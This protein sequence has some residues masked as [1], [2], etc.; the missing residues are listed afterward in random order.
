MKFNEWLLEENRNKT[1]FLTRN[2]SFVNDLIKKYEKSGVIV[3]N[4][5]VVSLDHIAK[6]IIIAASIYD[7]YSKDIISNN[8]TIWVLKELIDND[9]LQLTY[10]R[11]PED[12]YEKMFTFDTVKEIYQKICL[13]RANKYSANAEDEKND[14]QLA[15]LRKIIDVYEDKLKANN[16]IDGVGLIKD[17]LNVADKRE[18]SELLPDYI[19][20]EFVYLDEEFITLTN[21]EQNLINTL[22]NTF[23]G[24]KINFEEKD[25]LNKEYTFF[26]GYGLANEINYVVNDILENKYNFGDVTVLYTSSSMEPYIEGA[27]CG[28]NI[29]VSFIKGKSASENIVVQLIRNIIA[30]ANDDFSEEKLANILD[31]SLLRIKNNDGEKNEY[32]ASYKYS[33]DRYIKGPAKRKENKFVLG[34][35]YLR[36]Y[37]FIENEENVETTDKNILSMHN[38]LLEIFSSESKNKL[39]KCTLNLIYSR[40]LGFVINNKPKRSKEFNS[41]KD[42]LNE[43]GKEL[44]YSNEEFELTE[45]LDIVD[46]RLANSKISQ[47]ENGSVVS[48]L[49]FRDKEVIN[50]NNLYVV[51]MSMKDFRSNMTQSSVL[52]D[53]N[54]VKYLSD[55]F[56]PTVEAKEEKIK[57][58]LKF[59]LGN[60][61]GEKIVMGYS[62]YDAETH[63]QNSPSLFLKEIIEGKGID[64]PEEIT[65]F[66]YGN[67]SESIAEDKYQKGS[68]ESKDP[69]Q[70]FKTQKVSKTALEEFMRCPLKYAYN[71]VLNVRE[72]DWKNKDNTRWLNYTDRGTYCHDILDKYINAAFIARDISNTKF[73]EDYFDAVIKEANENILKVS[74]YPDNEGKTLS[75]LKQKEELRDKCKKYL[76]QTIF[77][78][79]NGRTLWTPVLTEYKFDEE[80][81]VKLEFKDYKNEDNEFVLN[82][83]ID[84]TDYYIKHDSK[85][86]ELRLIDYKTGKDSIIRKEN[87]TGLLIQHNVYEMALENE[88]V[89]K[90]IKERV[91]RLEENEEIK[92]YQTKVTEVAYVFPIDENA[93]D[94]NV[95]MEDLDKKEKGLRRLKGII[96]VVKNENRYV[97][98]MDLTS[99]IEELEK[100]IN[101]DME[102]VELEFLKNDIAKE[103]TKKGNPVCKNCKYKEFCGYKE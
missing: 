71:I 17:V 22:V 38:E 44:S 61:N 77:D 7:D 82:G 4:V 18:L 100:V 83:Q 88:S 31:S 94:L 32:V 64:K 58:D 34:W 3:E 33:P 16:Y 76:E 11:T 75:I 55:T 46:K 98:H 1:I 2:V 48:A 59:I 81:N 89:L 66:V 19:Y 47:P 35:G 60:F 15:D 51:G 93:H 91:A 85:T 40:I 37:E 5:S 25:Y 92:Q 54:M 84:R 62:S 45:A 53:E 29:P 23:K 24:K 20:T 63:S 95:Q 74:P 21:D 12:K 49:L 36:N 6:E 79:N 43:F 80:D 56:I 99:A 67:P 52:S 101:N 14:L 9:S 96:S 68:F 57:D 69:S 78:I 97:P 10:F 90:T 39:D 72:H 87:D 8:A 102:K 28:R 50:R 42:L 13:I 26:K 86:I 27:F 70:I 41:I 103:F 73:D 65:E 30:W